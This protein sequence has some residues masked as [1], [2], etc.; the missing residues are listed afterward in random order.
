MDKSKNSW[1]D[2]TGYPFTSHYFDVAGYNLHFIDEGQGETILFVHGTP[3]WSFDYRH[4]IKTLTSNFRCIA[5]DHIGFGL[6]DKP[7]QY[8]YSTQNY[9]AT[10]EKF[11][12]KKTT[13]KSDF[14]SSR[15]WGTYRVEL[16]YPK[17]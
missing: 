15:F 4:V 14:G 12:L 5:V 17:R 16:C 8:N 11:A 3:S 6:S 2:K 9:S 1:L 13:S 7:E 10:L